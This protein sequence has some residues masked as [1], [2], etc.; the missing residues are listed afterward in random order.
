MLRLQLRGRAMGIRVFGLQ[1][2]QS[3]QHAARCTGSVGSLKLARASR[4]TYVAHLRLSRNV[5]GGGLP[6][7]DPSSTDA[8]PSRRHA[9]FPTCVS[10]AVRSRF[11][12][13]F[14]DSFSPPSNALLVFESPA[15]LG[16]TPVG[17]IDP[18]P[19]RLS[20]SL[21]IQ[22][23]GP[24]WRSLLLFPFFRLPCPSILISL[25]TR[26]LT[27]L[28]PAI[29][30]R[31]DASSRLRSSDNVAYPLRPILTSSDN[32]DQQL[33]AAD[34]QTQPLSLPPPTTTSAPVLRENF[35][36]EKCCGV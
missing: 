36:N 12:S 15:Q 7:A 23:P 29:A 18:Y 26:R 11:L 14:R 35:I 34:T 32:V 16:S 27:N 8:S 21:S 2:L 19:S 3:R 20:P 13:S 5:V 22:V 31:A 10:L 9:L 17:E 6:I 4:A 24:P 28:P 25:A 1:P 33:R 30:S